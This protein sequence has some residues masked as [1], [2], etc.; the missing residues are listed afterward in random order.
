[1][2]NSKMLLNKEG[3]N[4]VWFYDVEIISAGKIH[5]ND[6]WRMHKRDKKKHPITLAEIILQDEKKMVIRNPF[7]FN[8]T[9]TY[10]ID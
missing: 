2:S 3:I 8:D 7:N 1:M 4:W 6:S 10:K 5:I 9:L